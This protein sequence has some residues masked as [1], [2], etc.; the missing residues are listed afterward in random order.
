[1]AAHR[2]ALAARRV[3]RRAA[4]TTGRCDGGAL[5]HTTRPAHRIRRARIRLRS[6]CKDPGHS[7]RSDGRS[8]ARASRT[9]R[10]AHRQRCRRSIR[11]C[12]RACRCRRGLPVRRTRACQRLRSD[13]R[14]TSKGSQGRP[15]HRTGR[16]AGHRLACAAGMGRSATDCH[17]RR[18]PRCSVR[19]GGHLPRSEA[20]LPR[21]LAF[22]NDRVLLDR[23]RRGEAWRWNDNAPPE[24]ARRRA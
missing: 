12:R 15:E 23:L 1:M 13:V 2:V 19:D 16:G 21:E 5:H 22:H 9:R 4:G 10:T 20:E 7:R 3:V 14:C 17:H 11:R 18:E 8:A 6:D 24:G